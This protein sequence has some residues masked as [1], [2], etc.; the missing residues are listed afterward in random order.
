[1]LHGDS[2]IA[3]LGGARCRA[4][5][6]LLAGRYLGSQVAALGPNEYIERAYNPSFIALQGALPDLRH[7]PSL[8]NQLLVDPCITF[9]GSLDLRGPELRARSGDLE[10]A[11]PLPEATAPMAGS[12]DPRGT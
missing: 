5:V 8:M 11:T 2:G 10:E 3:Y 6:R 7:T 9:D 12:G 4:E 1:M